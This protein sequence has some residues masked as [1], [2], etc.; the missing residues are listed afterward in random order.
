MGVSDVFLENERNS[1]ERHGRAH[2]DAR[3]TVRGTVRALAAF[4]G[5]L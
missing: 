4:P 1:L 3:S 2:D 5:R